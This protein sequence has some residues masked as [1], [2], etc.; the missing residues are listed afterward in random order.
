MHELAHVERP[1]VV[2]FGNL[3][4]GADGLTIGPTARWEGHWILASEVVRRKVNRDCAPV[5]NQFTWSHSQCR[6]SWS[7]LLKFRSP[8]G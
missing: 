5:V 4:W 1:E 3:K 2:V 6:H 8:N 7:L